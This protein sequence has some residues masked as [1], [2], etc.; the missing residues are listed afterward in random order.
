[1]Y[2]MQHI[3]VQRAATRNSQPAWSVGTGLDILPDR[4]LQ[5]LHTCCVHMANS[6]IHQ[7]VHTKSWIGMHGQASRACNY[8]LGVVQ[9]Q[10]CRRIFNGPLRRHVTHSAGIAVC[11]DSPGAAVCTAAD[12]R[13]QQMHTTAGATKGCSNMQSMLEIWMHQHVSVC[14]DMQSLGT[15][16]WIHAYAIHSWRSQSAALRP[17]CAL[18][19]GY[20]L[21]AYSAVHRP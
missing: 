17:E 11:G 20:M 14:K 9:H 16:W 19:N 5:H 10:I 21:V 15:C 3:L 4:Q 6:V 2:G 8:T 12:T 13:I 1:M 7:C 18:A